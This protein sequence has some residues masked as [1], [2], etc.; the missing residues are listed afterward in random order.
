MRTEL[1]RCS[2]W[3][4][5]DYHRNILAAVYASGI[6]MNI[7]ALKIKHGFRIDWFSR[8]IKFCSAKSRGTRKSRIKSDDLLREGQMIDALK[9]LVL[10]CISQLKRL[11]VIGG[12]LPGLCC[13]RGQGTYP[14][15]QSVQSREEDLLVILHLSCSQ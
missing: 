14:D 15:Y 3:Q 13:S 5:Q 9:I 12:R 1:R 6:P 10:F 2:F 4:Y 11:G 8:K 7:A